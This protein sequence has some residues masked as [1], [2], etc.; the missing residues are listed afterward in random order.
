M[1][2]IRCPI[3]QH[4]NLHFGKI[5]STTGTTAVFSPEG[6]HTWVGY[7]ITEAFVCLNC[8][9]VA[10]FIPPDTVQELRDWVE[11]QR[12]DESTKE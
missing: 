8:G 10:Y 6:R 5:R 11:E 9:H 3:C 4:T 7:S 12:S 2:E 1:A